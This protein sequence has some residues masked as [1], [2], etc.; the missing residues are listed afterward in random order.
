MVSL[1]EDLI[2]SMAAAIV[3][4]VKPQRVYLFG[5]WHVGHLRPTRM[6]IF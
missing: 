1:S 4:E 2:E 6:W 3:Q 5:S